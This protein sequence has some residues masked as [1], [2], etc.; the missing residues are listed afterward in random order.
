MRRGVP[1]RSVLPP[2]LTNFG[3]FRLGNPVCDHGTWC[4][5]CAS[6]IK[7]PRLLM[8]RRFKTD[9]CESPAHHMITT[10]RKELIM[11]LIPTTAND[12]QH[13]AYVQNIIKVWNAAGDA[14]RIT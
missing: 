2:C 4:E 12:Q 1:S 3:P 14:D 8:G 10:S 9:K 13:E 6:M 11:N 7:G 5:T